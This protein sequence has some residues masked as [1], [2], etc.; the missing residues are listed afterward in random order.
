MYVLKKLK[1]AHIDEIHRCG[2]L[3]HQSLVVLCMLKMICIV[4]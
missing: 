3:E 4:S 1:M 2:Q